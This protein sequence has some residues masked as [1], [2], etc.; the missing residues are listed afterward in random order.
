VAGDRVVVDDGRV[1]ATFLPQLGFVGI[2]VR[3]GDDELLAMPRTLEEHCT[4]AATGLP[5]LHPFANRLSL[6]QFDAF[7][8]RFDTRAV[9]RDRNGL[10]IHGTMHTRR[11]RVER[12]EAVRVTAS[13]TVPAEPAFPW[14]HRVTVAVTA[15]ESELT[16][17]TLVDNRTRRRMPV[18]FGWHPFF[19]LPGTPRE[20]WVLRLPAC[21]RHVLNH[22][23]LPT[24]ER[25]DQPEDCSPIGTRTYDDHFD[26]GAD[27]TFE[28][29]DGSR[30]LR[31]TFDEHYP[32]A[33]IYLPGPDWPL[34]GD[35]VCIE[36]MVAST[37]ALVAETAPV[38]GPEG[39][40][41]AAFT[42]AVLT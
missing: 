19:T 20:E 3:A 17:T 2:S 34:T 32:H 10:A 40:F 38:V 27:R 23:M 31:I 12:E 15:R 35:F 13:C 18:S 21:R 1:A 25:V 14:D 4:G 7:G 41:A 5:L 9:P 26:L 33:Q 39:T 16:V 11:F 8:A 37:N 22:R 28:L 29:S 30:T 24:G 42:V 6:D 36:P